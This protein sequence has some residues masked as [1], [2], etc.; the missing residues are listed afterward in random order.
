MEVVNGQ[1]EEKNAQIKLHKREI[2]RIFRAATE[3]ARVLAQAKEQA[4]AASRAKTELLA[5]MSHELR[6][7]LTAMLGFSELLVAELDG[8]EQ[9]ENVGTVLRNGEYLLRLIDDLLDLSR[10]EAGKF[11]MNP[12]PCSPRE[13]VSDVVELLK[14]RAQEKGLEFVREYEGQIPATIHCDATRLRQILIN[15]VG[16]ALKFTERGSVR[17][18]VRHIGGDAS[19]RHLEVRVIDTG[20]GIARDQTRRL[21]E[22]FA[23]ADTSST[24]RYG[25]SGLGLTI[26][27]HLAEL[28]G[29]GI[30]VDSQPGAGSEF[31]LTVPLEVAPQ[32]VSVGECRHAGGRTLGDSTVP[33]ATTLGFPCRILLAEDGP[34][35]QRLISLL[36]ERAGA[37]VTLVENGRQALEHGLQAE[38]EGQPYDLILMDVQ[39]PEMDGHVATARLREAE[40]RGPI[41]ALTAHTMKDDRKKCLEAG[42]DGYLGKP[43]RRDALVAAVIRWA[44]KP[45]LDHAR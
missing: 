32:H 28:L 23:Q 14:A 4:E 22:P 38:R 26:S 25:G 43:I 27:K 24:R 5:N 11:Q 18:V 3:H 9:K 16:N 2:H 6:T 13:I 33:E 34:D 1:L 39:M 7:P 30:T 31:T 8:R 17:V 37:E 36:L 12:A 41:V 40:Y 42:C 45:I 15:L 19:D 29:G 20:I 35:N 44:R 10:I 21:F